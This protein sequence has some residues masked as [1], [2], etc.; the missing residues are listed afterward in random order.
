MHSAGTP[1]RGENPKAPAGD[2]PGLVERQGSPLQRRQRM[3]P[4]KRRKRCI[5]IRA[6]KS[7]SK[8]DSEGVYCLHPRGVSEV[9]CDPPK[10]ALC[11]RPFGPK[12]VAPL[13]DD[14]GTHFLHLLKLEGALAALA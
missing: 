5:H 2:R 9:L 10:P 4:R 12:Y 14:T 7:G 13:D 6:R 8:A 1:Q 11:I 3:G